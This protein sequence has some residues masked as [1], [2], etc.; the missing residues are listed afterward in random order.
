MPHIGPSCTFR[1]VI[2]PYPYHGDTAPSTAVNRDLV[3]LAARAWKTGLT[4]DTDLKASWRRRPCSH[5][6]AATLRSIGPTSLPRYCGYCGNLQSD[7]ATARPYLTAYVG[8]S[9]GNVTYMAVSIDFQW[10]RAETGYVLV[11]PGAR[12]PRG[13]EHLFGAVREY[14]MGPTITRIAGELTSRG[15]RI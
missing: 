1:S 9:T 12:D 10:E 13:Q 6:T 2:H 14:L 4:G 8:Y 11:P 7:I 3:R 5:R 15:I